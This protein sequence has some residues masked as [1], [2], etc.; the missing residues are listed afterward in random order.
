MLRI[1]GREDQRRWTDRGCDGNLP[2]DQRIEEPD[3]V[4]FR[5]KI[6]LASG[7]RHPATRPRRVGGISFASNE[8]ANS[9]RE[10]LGAQLQSKSDESDSR[11]K[12]SLDTGSRLVVTRD[13]L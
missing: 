6:A 8:P 10:G 4:C 5:A 9:Q 12:W 3:R 2:V 7:T 11:P 13:A 1:T